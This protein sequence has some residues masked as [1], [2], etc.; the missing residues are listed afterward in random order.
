MNNTMGINIQP[1]LK[2]PQQYF[3]ITFLLIYNYL[4]LKE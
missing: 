2:I 1:I 4:I 3:N